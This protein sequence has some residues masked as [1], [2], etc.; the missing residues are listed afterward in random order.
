MHG[1]SR[2]RECHRHRHIALFVERNVIDQA[3][4]DDI[5]AQFRVIDVGQRV[6][7]IA[8]AFMISSSFIQ[9]LFVS[10]LAERASSRAA[11]VLIV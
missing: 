2:R 7:A 11:D 10:V 1:A 8:V 4:V 9:L 3:E 5:D 6:V